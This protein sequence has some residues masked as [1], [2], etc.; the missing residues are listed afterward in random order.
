M[1]AVLGPCRL[2]H[3]LLWLRRLLLGRRLLRCLSL[4]NHWLLII[5]SPMVL[6]IVCPI[7]CPVVRVVVRL[8]RVEAAFQAM[9]T[10]C[11]SC[12]VLAR[13]SVLVKTVL[14]LATKVGTGIADPIDETVGTEAMATATR[15]AFLGHFVAW[16]TLD[17]TAILLD[18]DEELALW[19]R[20]EG[21]VALCLRSFVGRVTA[22]ETSFK[23]LTCLVHMLWAV[24]VDAGLEAALVASE[25][26]AVLLTTEVL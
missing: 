20:H 25:D 14:L 17:V 7:V 8:L 12:G 4:L 10:V 15:N 11:G 23:L 9:S 21:V 24:A 1:L 18:G 5:V 16:S 2:G 26:T 6:T 19:A 22:V 13:L 3:R